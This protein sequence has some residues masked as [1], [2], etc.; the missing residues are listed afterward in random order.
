LYSPKI[1][2]N[3]IPLI[4]QKAKT[5]KKPMTKI[6]NEILKEKLSEEVLDKSQVNYHPNPLELN[7]QVLN[8][9]M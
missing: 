1:S 8:S 3:L 2:E 9:T 7:E 4:Y 5:E 6:V